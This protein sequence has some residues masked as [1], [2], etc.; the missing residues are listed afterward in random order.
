MQVG[1]EGTYCCGWVPTSLR[2]TL[3]GTDSCGPVRPEQVYPYRLRGLC[4]HSE[5]TPV[6]RVGGGQVAPGSMRTA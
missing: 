6:L 3:V 5:G 2:D 4:G 1:C